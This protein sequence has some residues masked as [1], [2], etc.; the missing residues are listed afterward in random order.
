[1]LTAHEPW[2]TILALLFIWLTLAL[3]R[4]LWPQTHGL[5]FIAIIVSLCLCMY[6][7]VTQGSVV[8]FAIGLALALSLEYSPGP[9]M[10]IT[11][12]DKKSED[13]GIHYGDRI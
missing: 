8:F 4:L 11:M 5:F 10:G 2:P 13:E 9:I 6:W 1:M 12:A 7:G 3:L